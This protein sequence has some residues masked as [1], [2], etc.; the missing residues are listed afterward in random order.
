MGKIY[1]IHYRF[2]LVLKFRFRF[3]KAYYYMRYGMMRETDYPVKDSRWFLTQAC[4]LFYKMRVLLK[5]TGSGSSAC[6][7]VQSRSVLY[8]GY[9]G[10][11]GSS[12]SL[13]GGYLVTFGPPDSGSGDHS[14][15]ATDL[16]M[17]VS[18]VYTSIHFF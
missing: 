13:N 2:D 11:I 17:D 7:Y 18:W 8:T 16:F 6:Q 9:L 14:Q 10:T 4:D 5:Y 12:P 1:A 15:N 3:F